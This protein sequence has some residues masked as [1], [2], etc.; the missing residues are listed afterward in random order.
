MFNG[1]PFS[2][3][4]MKIKTLPLVVGAAV[5]LAGTSTTV[6][7]QELKRGA[8]IL[9]R[10]KPELDP[11]G[12]RAGS[13]LIF[14]KVELG[15]TYD[16]NVF[17]TDDK[18]LNGAG[19]L[20][21]I[22][23]EGDFL[24]QVLPT[25]TAQSDFSRHQ[26]RFSTGADIGRY[27]D[28]TSENYIDYFVTGSGRFDIT[29]DSA[30][31]SNLSY[32]QLHEDRGDP[33]SPTTA[34]EP[35]EFTRTNAELAYQQRFNRVTGRIGIGAE[36]EDYDDA[37]SESGTTLNQ[38][39]RDNWA[40]SATGQ[41][42]Y[43]LYPGYRPFLRF[44]YTRTEYDEGTVKANS[45]TYEA[46]VGTTL[47]LT[48][49][50][51]GEVFI[52][53]LNRSYDEENFGNFTGMAYGLKLD[54][55]VTQ[56]TSISG[57]IER[58]VEEGFSTTSDPLGRTTANP[59]ERTTFQIGVDHELLRNVVLSALAQYQIDDYQDT[60]QEE[61]FYLLQAGATYNINRNFYL[62]GTYSYSMRDS[63]EPFDDYD[64]NL[65]LLRVGAQL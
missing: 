38:D 39:T 6:I 26:L 46:V 35:I 60:D 61:D 16:D 48:D 59:R 41:V 33:D 18:G 2:V 24:F 12:V 53:Y 25:V 3:G 10:P 20:V 51:T 21:K 7:A 5:L 45:D 62:R 4:A 17:A 57:N 8:S 13:F 64:R 29:G 37:V 9:D 65:F 34:K 19:Q 36:N 11:L 56:L 27:A 50:L 47:D 15:T 28:L 43:D 30:L 52:G 1:I 55:A 63:S 23:K 49:L 40:Y 54:Y 42:G 31:L 32:R 14:P 58:G 44:T 22:K